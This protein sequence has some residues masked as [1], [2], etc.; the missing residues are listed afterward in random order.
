MWNLCSSDIHDQ[1]LKY[2][3]PYNI[4]PMK[5]KETL[6]KVE[7]KMERGRRGAEGNNKRLNAELMLIKSQ[8]DRE[9][10]RD[11]EGELSILQSAEVRK[12]LE[13][14]GIDWGTISF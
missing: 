9:T 11:T 12:E 4:D 3:I 5:L 14:L 6:T 13:R 7:N 2:D 1:A 10:K 8:I